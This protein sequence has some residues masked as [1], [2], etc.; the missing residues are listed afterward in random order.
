MIYTSTH[1]ITSL[2][3]VLELKS[4]FESKSYDAKGVFVPFAK[5][6]FFCV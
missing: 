5:R 1:T 2:T 6:A 3:H 4:D